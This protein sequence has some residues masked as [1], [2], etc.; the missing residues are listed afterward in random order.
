M[1][2]SFSAPGTG[3]NVGD[4]MKNNAPVG[5]TIA[6]DVRKVPTF[7]RGIPPSGKPMTGA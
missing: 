3:G 4:M 6:L 2:Q 7:A 1:L 5:G